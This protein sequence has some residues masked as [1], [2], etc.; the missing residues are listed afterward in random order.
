MRTISSR[1]L[2]PMKRIAGIFILF[3]APAAMANNLE[4]TIL[5]YF[6]NRLSRLTCS[7]RFKAFVD[8]NRDSFPP[9]S[10]E[11]PTSVRVDKQKV[12]LDGKKVSLGVSYL[13]VLIEAPPVYVQTLLETP[14]WYQS[15]YAL[16]RS[17][18]MGPPTE[19]GSFKAHIYKKLPV[20][21]N[22]EFVLAYSRIISGELWFQRA[23]LHEDRCNFALRDNLRILEPVAGGVIYREISFVYPLKWWARALYP[24]VKGAMKKEL[25]RIAS[26]LKCTAEKRLPFT[27]E[28]ANDC[29]AAC[30]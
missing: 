24:A 23:R 2:L 15:L 19:S 16:D 17:A 25:N 28:I 13:Q 10:R 7:V 1:Y 30:I 3:T 9:L 21:P 8:Q 26:V 18:Y 22:Q 11:H 6:D 14:E 5:K 29:W 4:E 27:K 20:V 12:I